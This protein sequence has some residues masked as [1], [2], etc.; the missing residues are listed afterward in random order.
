M[1]TAKR[2]AGGIDPD[3]VDALVGTR[4]T[5]DIDADTVLQWEMVQ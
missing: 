2:P 1:L 4:A 3:R 5:V